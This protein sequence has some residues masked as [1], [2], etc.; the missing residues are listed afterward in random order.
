MRSPGRTPTK[1][2][3]DL[4]GIA[5]STRRFSLLARTMYR[6]ATAEL[7]TQPSRRP[8]AGPSE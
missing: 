3:F 5:G 7:Q 4:R 8:Y 2:G 6:D 1:R